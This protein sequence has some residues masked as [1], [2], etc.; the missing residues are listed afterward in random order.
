MRCQRSCERRRAARAH[1]ARGS[2]ASSS[3]ALAAGR[4]VEAQARA[5]AGTCASKRQPGTRCRAP[6]PC[7]ARSRRT[8]RRRRSDGPACARCTRIWCVRPVLMRHVE[9]REAGKA[10]RHLHQRDRAPAVVVVGVDARTRRSPCGVEVLVQRHVDHL[11]GS[12]ARRRRP[13]RRRSC[14]SSRARGTASCSASAR[15]ASWR[16]AA[17]PRSPCRAGAPARGSAPAGRARRSCSITPKLTPLPPCTAT[18]AGL[19]MASRCSSSNSDREL[20]RRRRAA[21]RRARPCAPA[22]RAPRRRAPSRV[23]APARPLL[24][25]TSPERMTR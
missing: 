19:S 10:L 11:R 4:M 22:A 1:C 15:C 12:P 7:S 18:P 23:S 16:A 20:A 25:R 2:G 17:R 6:A 21:R 8:C 5:R 13:A 3:I 9:Q 14:R 24:T